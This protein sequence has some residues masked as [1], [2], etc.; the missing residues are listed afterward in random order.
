MKR[1]ENIVAVLDILGYSQLLEEMSMDA[2]ESLIE[3][4]LLG[5]LYTAKLLSNEIVVVDEG[6]ELREYSKL[7]NVEYGVISDTIVLYPKVGVNNPLTT[8]CTTVSVLMSE[9]LAV[10]MLL[11]GAIDVGTFR[12]LEEHTIFIGQ[13]IIRAHKLEI[14][15]NWSGCSLTGR[16]ARRFSNEL[17][18]LRSDGLLVEYTI[19]LKKGV[20]HALRP[21]WALNWFY[22]QLNSNP[23]EQKNRLH[24]ELTQAPDSAK[25]K[26][27]AT[28]RFKE[29]LDSVGLSCCAPVSKTL[30]ERSNIRGGYRFLPRKPI[31]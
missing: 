29:F 5:A 22:Y 26:V 1:D 25:E 20:D 21:R 8:L 11:R 14:A 9:L 17:K 19:P 27:L 16:T 7:V 15:Q 18:H 10:G 3:H 2:L 13:A 30:Y 24:N 23:V 12:K 6:W 31:A 4:G 28:I